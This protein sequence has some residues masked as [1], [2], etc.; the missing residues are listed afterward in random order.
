M[1]TITYNDLESLDRYECSICH[2]TYD[3]K[4][5]AL[6]CERQTVTYEGTL[7]PKVGEN[8]LFKGMNNTGP[9]KSFGTIDK[10]Y[11][12]PRNHSV[13]VELSPDLLPTNEIRSPNFM[14]V[15]S[16]SFVTP[17]LYDR[18]YDYL[19]LR[20]SHKTVRDTLLIN[21]EKNWKQTLSGKTLIVAAQRLID[22]NMWYR[23][24]FDNFPPEFKFLVKIL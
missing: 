3:D 4:Y 14:V 10:I 7:V 16:D 9:Y 17:A 11:I 8:I 1:R 5:E 15:N 21:T 12:E 19:S 22:A 18:Y 2:F 13:G 23:G 6:A 20:I 24:M